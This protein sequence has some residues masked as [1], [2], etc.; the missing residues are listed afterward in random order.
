M[1][2]WI[3]NS[4]TVLE[5]NVDVHFYKD[6]IAAASILDINNP[7]FQDFELDI[8]EACDIRGFELI[9]E[10]K[11]SV[12][13]SNSHYC[14]FVKT[15]EDGTRLK[16]YLKI[17]ISDHEIGDDSRRD[18]P[19]YSKRDQDY[20]NKRAKQYAQENFGQPRGYRARR[21]DIVFNDDN[22]TSY[23]SALRAIEDR[24]D[25]FCVD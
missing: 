21:I 25:D 16:V 3:N 11:S 5:L 19:K 12:A 1:K 4:E 18:I 2:S 20:V 23:E 14:T 22:Y 13:G 7:A 10:S 15:T 9:D 24:L 6:D 8:L 17:R